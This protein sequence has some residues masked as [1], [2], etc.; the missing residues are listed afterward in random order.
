MA[1]DLFSSYDYILHGIIT[2]SR[3][4]NVCVSVQR[5]NVY[6]KPSVK[7]C[8]HKR[9]DVNVRIKIKENKQ[10]VFSG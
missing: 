3:T 6:V 5:N 9:D 2:S 4:R 7:G 8:V 1:G 10:N